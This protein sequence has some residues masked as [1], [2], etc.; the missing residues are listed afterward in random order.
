MPFLNKIASSPIVANSWKLTYYKEQIYKIRQQLLSEQSGFCAYTEDF[1]A[2]NSADQE[3]E[4]FNKDLKKTVADGYYNWYVSSR[5]VNSPKQK[6]EKLVPDVI[7]NSSR[8]LADIAADI[9]CDEYGFFAKND[10][11]ETQE[12]I[13][14]LCLDSSELSEKIRQQICFLDFLKFEKEVAVEPT[15]FQFPEKFLNYISAVAC[16]L[17]IPD[18][19]QRWQLEYPNWKNKNPQAVSDT[20]NNNE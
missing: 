17:Q 15:L 14:F 18:L 9:D 16:Y 10:N 11:A 6:G 5:W 7:K 1:I 4:H 3:L 8:S 13:N 2:H 20:N 12:L 19:K